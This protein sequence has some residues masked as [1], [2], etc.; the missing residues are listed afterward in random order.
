MNNIID[1]KKISILFTSKGLSY[2]LDAK[3]CINEDATAR[4]IL[5]D[6][7]RRFADM[8][9]SQ[10]FDRSVAEQLKAYSMT[11]LQ[12]EKNKRL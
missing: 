8:V 12:I 9:D 11:Q 5:A 1:D 6:L 10:T 3:D 2:V 4:G 7:I